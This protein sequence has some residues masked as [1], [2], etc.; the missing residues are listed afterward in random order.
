MTHRLLALS[1][2]VAVAPSAL[3]QKTSSIPDPHNHKDIVGSML[4]DIAAD[5][6]IYE[7]TDAPTPAEDEGAVNPEKTMRAYAV[8]NEEGIERVFVEDSRLGIFYVI[9]GLPF[10]NRPVSDVTWVKGDLLV[11]DRSTNPHMGVHYVV[12]MQ[13]KRL[14]VAALLSD[15]KG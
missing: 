11:F 5:V 14:V 3:A 9:D 13:K 7:V 6:R 1:F 15:E 8:A 12:D 10:P 2:L 4:D